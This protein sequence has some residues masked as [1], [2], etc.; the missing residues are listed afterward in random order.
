MTENEP[1]MGGHRLFTQPRA[2]ADDATCS[3]VIKGVTVSGN[4]IAPNNAS[5]ILDTVSVTGDVLVL[6]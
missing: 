4:V 2:R 1:E 6:P 5:C 3:G